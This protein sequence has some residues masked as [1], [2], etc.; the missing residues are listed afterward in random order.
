VSYQTAVGYQA[1][2]NATTGTQNLA[3]GY[4]AGSGITTGSNNIA[5]GYNAQ[6]LSATESNQLSIGNW[7]YGSAGDI[8]IG[9][10]SPSTKLHVVGSVRFDLGSD[11]SGDMYYR[12]QGVLPFQ[13]RR[14]ALGSA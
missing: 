4:Q 1:L 13:L 6:V 3:L 11:A 12:D 2:W 7:I 9:T 8:G 10:P 5:I 14:L